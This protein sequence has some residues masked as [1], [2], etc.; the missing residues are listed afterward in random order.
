[1][2]NNNKF[3][4]TEDMALVECID[5]MAHLAQATLGQALDM[6]DRYP[7]ERYASLRE[8]LRNGVNQ[9]H[10]CRMTAQDLCPGLAVTD[11]TQPY[12]PEQS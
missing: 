3:Q 6:L 5:S 9:A 1:M 11:D 10:I 7:G 8:S 4:P 2:G 12:E